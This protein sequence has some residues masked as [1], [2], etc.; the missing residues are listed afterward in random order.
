MMLDDVNSENNINEQDDANNNND[1]YVFEEPPLIYENI[2]YR[3]NERKIALRKSYFVEF[4][5]DPH[6]KH[7]VSFKISKEQYSTLSRVIYDEDKTCNDGNIISL[8][9]MMESS[10]MIILYIFLTNDIHGNPIIR[11][12]FFASEKRENLM[13]LDFDIATGLSLIHI[14]GLQLFVIQEWYD[15]R[16]EV[17]QLNA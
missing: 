5:N 1:A 4:Q 15:T 16:K 2:V 11:F 3:L 10:K 14:M 8:C 9:L 17:E 12:T 13:I 6:S 7:C